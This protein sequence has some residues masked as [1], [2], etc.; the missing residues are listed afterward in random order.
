M[1]HNEEQQL[2]GITIVDFMT[3]GDSCLEYN[4]MT[5]LKERE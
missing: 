4:N 3:A 1:K 2:I 5:L